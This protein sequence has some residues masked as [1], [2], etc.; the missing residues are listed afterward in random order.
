MFI[1]ICRAKEEDE[2]RTDFADDKLNYRDFI[3]RFFLSTGLC[4]VY[5]YARQKK[6]NPIKMCHFLL[7]IC[8]DF[9]INQEVECLPMVFSSN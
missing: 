3:Y 2:I 5:G 9:K 7:Y 6:D 8:G 1:Y 4:I